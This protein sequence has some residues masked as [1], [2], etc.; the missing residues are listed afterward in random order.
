[1][2]FLG[3]IERVAEFLHIYFFIPDRDNEA[4][5]G[6]AAEVSD[7][8]HLGHKFIYAKQHRDR[9][10]GDTCARKRGKRTGKHDKTGT[11]DAHRALASYHQDDENLY[12]MLDA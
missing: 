11:R 2:K 9:N 10:D 8:A 12:Q 5:Y 6:V 4:A 1:M 7:R 3:V